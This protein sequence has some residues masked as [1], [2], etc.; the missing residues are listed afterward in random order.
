[1]RPV[2]LTHYISNEK[3]DP[4]HNIWLRATGELPDDPA[5]QEAVLAYASDMTLVD[6]SLFA[7]GRS[8][9]DPEMQVASLDH[10][11]WF[12]RPFTM[13]DWHLYSQDSPSAS[14]ARGF[15]RGQIFS[16][17]GTLIASVAQEGLIRK[18]RK[19]AD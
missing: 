8:V 12:H 5:I 7:H 3:L 17:D 9:F 14:G 10:A 11:I 2:D 16:R 1:L 6:T 4:V 15:A 13:S 19:Q 18:R